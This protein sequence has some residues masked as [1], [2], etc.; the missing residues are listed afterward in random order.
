MLILFLVFFT[1]VCNFFERLLY[2]SSFNFPEVCFLSIKFKRS[3]TEFN[4][5][6][7]PAFSS[8]NSFFDLALVLSLGAGFK[9]KS[10]LSFARTFSNSPVLGVSSLTLI[11]FLYLF[12]LLLHPLSLLRFFVIQYLF[13]FL[14]DL[15]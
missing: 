6:S 14:V 11:L 1:L 8:F 4:L 9:V 5:V 13:D 3:S 15:L 12:Q 7:N 10:V 2:S